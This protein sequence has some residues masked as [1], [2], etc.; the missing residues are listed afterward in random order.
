MLPRKVVIGTYVSGYEILSE[1]LD[2]R[3][4]KMDS[5]VEAMAGKAAAAF[6]SKRL[7]L[8]VL[9]EFFVARNGA[10]LQ[11]KLVRLDEVLPRI[12]AC[13]RRYHT[14]LVVPALLEE[15]AEPAIRSNAAVFVDRDGKLI[16]LYRKAHPVAPI[17]SNSLE[18]GTMPGAEY[19]VF[20]TDIG[21]IGLQ[22]CYD[23]MYPEGWRALAD[24]GAEIV[25]LP[26]ASAATARPSLYALQHGYYVVSATPRDHAAVYSPIGIIE[27][28]AKEQGEILVHQIDLSY[29]L[30][31]WDALLEEGAALDKKFGAKVGYRYY[32]AEDCGIFWSND[33]K[34]SIGSM[35]A[36]L[37]LASEASEVERIRGLQDKARGGPAR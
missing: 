4:D 20:T 19:P 5:V 2:K 27:A 30:L 17:G 13:A 33:P 34:Q 32:R 3:L 10:T 31:H 36:T 23:M 26:S 24:K 25:V 18:E 28:E 6:P 8:A 35:I 29:A 15:S 11:G 22:I 1:S 37:N 14:L 21:R 12:S 9:P 16:G 7:D